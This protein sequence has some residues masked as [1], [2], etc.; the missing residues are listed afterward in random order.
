MQR[1][2]YQTTCLE[3]QAARICDLVVVPVVHLTKLGSPLVVLLLEAGNYADRL[4]LGRLGGTL[5]TSKRRLQGAYPLAQEVVL[6]LYQ[7]QLGLGA[8]GTQC[9]DVRFLIG[10]NPRPETLT[11]SD[12]KIAK[13]AARKAVL[14]SKSRLMNSQP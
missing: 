5:L 11:F 2:R 10:A 1:L 14:R 3:G 4:G 7:C 13:A 12:R 6:G 8:C 9:L